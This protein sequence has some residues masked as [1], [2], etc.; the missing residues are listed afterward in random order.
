MDRA[1]G[2]TPLFGVIS[3]TLGDLYP[4]LPLLTKGR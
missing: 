4:L 2:E 3:S 1:Y